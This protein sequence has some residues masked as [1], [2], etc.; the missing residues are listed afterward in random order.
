MKV[1]FVVDPESGDI[2]EY[3]PYVGVNMSIDDNVTKIYKTGLISDEKM[4]SMKKGNV[5]YLGTWF[6][7]DFDGDGII[8]NVSFLGYGPF[9]RYDYKGID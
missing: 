9:T 4:R 2:Y 5:E 7:L 6:Y 1:K 3:G 8:E